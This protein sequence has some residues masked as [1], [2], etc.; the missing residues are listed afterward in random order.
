MSIEPSSLLPAD[1]Y[2]MRLA[3][4]QAQNAW[5]VG[6]VPVGA[7]IMRAGQVIAT[8]YN[9]PITTHDPTA[10]AEI[11]ALR[12]AAQ[13]L[14]NYRLPECE[15]YVTL[16]PCAMCAMA[17]MHA[18]L[19]RVV[20]AAPDPKTGVAGSVLD[21]FDQK[22]L[23]HHTALQGGVLAEASAKLLREFF[24]ER[25]EAARQLRETRRQAAA[26]RAIEAGAAVDADGLPALTALPEVQE[27]PV[28]PVGDAQ[29]LSPNSDPPQDDPQR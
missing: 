14:G 16:E 17:M 25:R 13:L 11:V 19:K 4:D 21:L 22:Q 15:L 9:R 18:R 5:L 12:H 8:G 26:E 24:A 3:L 20:F 28:I 6:E 10:H 27:F 2:A 23:N 1:E 7:V 29:Y